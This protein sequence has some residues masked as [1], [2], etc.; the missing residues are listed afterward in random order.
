MQQTD[1][2][3]KLLAFDNGRWTVRRKAAL[4]QAVRSGLLNLQQACERYHLSVEELRA[5]ERDFD[6]H[7]VYGLRATRLQIYRNTKT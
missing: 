2:E 5:W 4:L 7:G 1:I 3:L 6:K